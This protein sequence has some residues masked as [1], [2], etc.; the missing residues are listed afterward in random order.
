MA[1]AR[2]ASA[3][4]SREVAA[5]RRLR[6][7]PRRHDPQRRTAAFGRTTK[8]GADR[9]AS[10][11]GVGKRRHRQPGVLGEE[12]HDAVDVADLDRL[13]EA[14]D[15][16]AFLDGVGER[17]PFTAGGGEPRVEC[18]PRPA[19]QAVHRR[20]GCVEELGCLRRAVAEHVAEHE[21]RALVRRQVLQADDEG[22]SDRL[23]RFRTAPPVRAP[24][25]ER[26]R[27]ARRD[28]ARARA[29]RS[30]VSARGGASRSACP[31][32]DLSP[33]ARRARGWWQSGKA[34]YGL[35]RAPR[36]AP[37]RARRRGASLGAGPRRPAASRPS[38][39]DGP[40]ARAGTGR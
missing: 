12:R 11:V 24:R 15:E 36:T 29:A 22:E 39:R 16:L 38:G 18:R 17:R 8:E 13:G 14:A 23:S 6:V 34:T 32:D 7:G 40:G 9:R 19:E 30:S 37:G 27:G 35:T 28:T 20:L 2:P 33:A 3:S 31:V 25:R 21:H 4:G 1:N 5:E 10:L 26:R